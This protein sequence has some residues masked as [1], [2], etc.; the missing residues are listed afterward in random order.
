MLG[1]QN[2]KF[3]NPYSELEH[4]QQQKVEVLASKIENKTRE[5]DF[6]SFLFLY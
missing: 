2:R 3:P 6:T 4:I 5:F 1:T